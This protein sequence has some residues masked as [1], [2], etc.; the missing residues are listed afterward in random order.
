MADLNVLQLLRCADLGELAVDVG[1]E[2]GVEAPLGKPTGTVH[3][4]HGHPCTGAFGRPGPGRW[5]S[6]YPHA[7][8]WLLASGCE[9]RAGSADI[10][11]MLL[12]VF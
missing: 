4:C 6:A 12:Y 9:G 2:V 3:G 5:D 11:H 7:P 10:T 8:A 1:G